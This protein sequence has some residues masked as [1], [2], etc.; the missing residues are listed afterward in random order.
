MT[1]QTT[2][3]HDEP[4]EGPRDDDYSARWRCRT[5][6]HRRRP[7]ADRRRR[8]AAARRPPRPRSSSQLRDAIDDLV[9][10]AGPTV[11]TYSAKAA[12]RRRRRRRQGGPFARKAGEATADASGSSPRSRAAWA[13]DLRG[14]AGRAAGE[15]RRAGRRHDRRARGIDRGDADR[16]RRDGC[17]RRRTASPARPL[18]Y[19]SPP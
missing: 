5:M 3:N 1:D 15:R 16:R 11:E 9:E 6:R 18:R 14:V 12:E 2:P 8:R 19:T 13:A 17:T 4:A 10:R 7:W